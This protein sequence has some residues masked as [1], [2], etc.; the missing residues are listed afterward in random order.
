MKH[1]T[2][3]TQTRAFFW[4]LSSLLVA[5]L[6]MSAALP[7]LANAATI[8]VTNNNDSGAG[9]LRQAITDTVASDTIT[10]DSS[11]AGQTITL[12]SQLTI[13]KNL[14]IDGTGQNITISGNNAVRVFEVTAGTVTFDSLIIANGN[15]S[16]STGS[17]GGGIFNSNG[18]VTVLNSTFD[19]NVANNSGGAIRNEQTLTVKNSTFN[20][21]S[22]SWAGG[23]I[24]NEAILTVKNSTFSGNT[25]GGGNGSAILNG[26]AGTLNLLN[27]ILANS[28]NNSDCYNTGSISTNTNNLIEDNSCNPALSGDSMLNALA[29]NGGDTQTMALQLGSPAIAAGDSAT[30]LTTDQRGESRQTNCDI[31]AY[32]YPSVAPVAAFGTALDFDGTDDYVLANLVTTAIDNISMEAWIN[33]D[34]STSTKQVIFYNG[35]STTNGY[36]LLVDNATNKLQ[37]LVGG[38]IVADSDYVLSIDG[39]HHVALIRRSG[40]WELYVDGNAQTLTSTSTPNLPTGQTG[41]AA[42]FSGIEFFK[43]QLDEVRIWAVARTQ[44]Q[45]QANM[46]QFLQG[47]ESGLVG[48][49]RFDEGTG[50]TAYDSTSNNNHGTLTNMDAANWFDASGDYFQ[51]N[52]DTALS[53]FMIAYDIDGDSL[54]YSIVTNGSKG[55]A[56]FTDPANGD[57]TYTPNADA[58]G[59]D[60]FTY[61]VNDG[62]TDSN[63]VTAAMDITADNDA[64]TFTSTEVTSATAGSVYTYNITTNDVDNLGTELTIT[65]PTQ[66]S[67][68]TT[69]TDNGDGTAFLSG[70]PDGSDAGNHGISLQVSDGTATGTQ[71]FIVNVT[72]VTNPTVANTNDSGAGSLRDAIIAAGVGD[73]ITFDSS[74]AGQTIT[75]SSQLTIGKDLTIDGGNNNITLSGNGAVRIL[76]T[77]AGDITLNNLTITDGSTNTQDG[78]A[79]LVGDSTTSLTINGCTFSNNMAGFNYSGGVIKNEALLLVNNSTFLDN[80]AGYAGAILNSGDALISNST[81]YHNLSIQISGG[82]AA[83]KNQTGRTMTVNNSTLSDNQASNASGGA[84]I[85]NEGT[86]HLT[87]TIIANSLGGGDCVNNGTL[88]TN[89]NN[90]IED[91]SCSATLNGDPNLGSLQDNSGPTHTMSLLP[92]SVALNAG[93]NTAC[94]STDQRG[95]SRPQHNTCDIGA[96]EKRP[97]AFSSTAT[98]SVNEDSAYTYN[99]TLTYAETT[100]GFTPVISATVKPTWLTLTDN[101]DGTGT[102]VGTPTN[103]EVGTHNVTLYLNYGSENVVQSFIITVVNTN[104]APTFTSTALTSVNEDSLYT[105]NITSTDIDVGDTLSLTAPTKP[106]WLTLTDNGNGTGTLTGTPTNAEVGIHNVT[107]RVNDGTVDVD[108]TFT[109]TVNNTNDAPTFTSTAT[110]TINEDS[111][112]SYSITTSDLDVGDSLTFSTPV[113][114]AWLT[115]T[116]N[117][118]GTATLTGT[119]TNS[120]V[121]SHNVTL[122]VNDGTVNLDQSFTVTVNNSNDLPIFTST[123]ITSSDEDSPYSY[124]IAVSE[125]DVTDTLTL[126]ASTK[127]AWLT[128][129]DNG[130]G[131]GTLAGTPTNA[132]VGTHNVTLRVNDGTVNVDQNFTVSVNNINDAPTFTSTEVTAV[133]ED[134]TYTYNIVASDVDVGNSLTLTAP[135]QPAW[136]T[137][138]DNGDGTATLTGTPTNT[139][140]GNNNVTLRVSDG[141]V[142]VDQSFTVTVAK[143]DIYQLTVN[144]EGNGTITTDGINCGDDCQQD[145]FNGTSVTLTATPDS[146]WYFSGLQGDCDSTGTVVINSEKSC[147]VTFVEEQFTLT[148]MILGNGTLTGDN[149]DCDDN[150]TVNYPANTKV[151]LTAQPDQGWQFD[152]FDGDCE[153]DGKIT[154]SSN[155]TCIATFIKGDTDGVSTEIED[156]APNNGD[157]NGDGLKD[158]QQAEV[159]SGPDAV[160][161]AYITLVIHNT[162]CTLQYIN[163]VSLTPEAGYHYPQGQIAFELDNCPQTALTVYYHGDVTGGDGYRQYGPTVPGDSNNTWYDLPNVSLQTATLPNGQTVQTATLTLVD[164]QPGDETAADGSI[165]S[166]GGLRLQV[167]MVGFSAPEYQVAEDSGPATI[168]VSRLEGDTRTLTID[169]ATSDDTAIAGQDYQTSLGTLIWADGQQGDQT[170]TIDIIDNTTHEGDRTLKISLS[171]LTGTGAGMANNTAFLTIHD[172][173]TSPPDGNTDGNTTPPDG[174]TGGSTTS[175][176][177]NTGDSTTSPDG[178]TGDSTTSPDGSTGGSTTPPDGSTGG[179][180]T[181]PDGS[182]DGT[183]TPSDGAVDDTSALPPSFKP[184]V[185]VSGAVTGQTFTGDTLVTKGASV[186]KS[187]FEGN[188]HNQGLVSNSTLKAGALLTGGSL[189]GTTTNN[190]TIT[191]IDFVGTKLSGGTL[192]GTITNSSQIGGTISNV[193][194]AAG[195][196]VK[197][198]ILAGNIDSQGIVSDTTIEPGALL[199]GGRLA[200]TIT[201]RG[202]ITNIEFTG[203]KLSGGT[204]SGTITNSSENGLIEDVQLAAGTTVKGG[205]LAGEIRGDP[206]KPALIMAA[207]IAPGTI[208]SNVHLSST[209]QLPE[210]VVL[211]PGV[212]PATLEDFGLTDEALTTLDAE[213]L[214]EL[215]P[216]VF[217][218]L[219]P[220]QLESIPPEAFSALKPEQL[221]EVQKDTLA[222]LTPEQFEQMPLEALGGLTKDNMGGLPTDVINQITPAHLDA[223]NSDEFKQMPSEDVSKLFTNLDAENVIPQDVEQLIPPGWQVAPDGALT[224]PVGAK[225]TLR[226]LLPPA[227]LPAQVA[228]PSVPDFSA[229][230]G[231]GGRGTPLTT[232]VTLSLA[233]ANLAEFVLSQPKEKGGVLLVKGTG[234]SAGIN[235]SFIPD[236]DNVIQVDTDE[237]PIGLSEDDGG[238][239]TI[240]TPYGQQFKVIPAPQNPVELSKALGDGEVVLGKRGDVMMEDN[241]QTQPGHTAHQVGI[242]DPLIK[243]AP[244]GLSPGLYLPESRTSSEPAKVVYPDGT[245]QT[246]TPTMLSPDTFTEEG[247]EFQGVKDIVFKADGTYSFTYKGQPYLVESHFGLQIGNFAEGEAVEASI[248]PSNGIL[249]Y[250]VVIEEPEEQIRRTHRG[251]GGRRGRSSGNYRRH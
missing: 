93:D 179:T 230:F 63:I 36:G 123:A 142:D 175:P 190:G 129:T 144:K 106:T 95:I 56:N 62:T 3:T 20:S 134:S 7:P 188:I 231:I 216:A 104:D 236:A 73:T 39:W 27:T 251:R 218:V 168:T 72:A 206:N 114:P 31:G 11:I 198:G 68:L 160:T 99:I 159:V 82:G 124:S 139:D 103:N 2:P 4:P 141:T 165:V 228:L 243:P 23:G 167:G 77:T 12:S 238:F 208:L 61:K 54:T 91:G 197:G 211:G 71:N 42:T 119:P 166:T 202:T 146:G 40:T 85:L 193:Q 138:T 5:M 84:G 148:V 105:Y 246:F 207:Q 101:N 172:N 170:F 173:D 45:I 217:G 209:V 64:P 154:L 224:A 6:L 182:T 32:E 57:F 244:E 13:N 186:S 149:I 90:L 108:Q 120:E 83:L 249:T 35:N 70:T 226:T 29:N 117:G 87:N 196:I 245:M 233:E 191:N 240:T 234:N 44:A 136:L 194:L 102:L 92:N 58:T 74:I 125:V 132:E 17:S 158:S 219:E 126:T 205:T 16:N 161:G 156:A 10:F 178:S 153:I 66:P 145:Y 122:R 195:T 21:N 24:S 189:S 76:E 15:T 30:C 135:T 225:V 33:W 22:A 127:P 215:E 94:E 192:S 59:S 181:P 18:N 201:N 96:Y 140:V 250:T 112:Y 52:E 46:H 53:S 204:L 171:N 113:K 25:S 80:L 151:T 65:A 34:G 222:E 111:L 248:A 157:G 184:T 187:V 26:S 9:S 69:L 49:W 86:L 200:G 48:Y 8:T 152:G 137:L 115:L 185:V 177:G 133:S 131:T 147:T 241:G 213:T 14:A 47:N 130:N 37:L 150:C 41:L 164:G 121:G 81:F 50:M 203:A 100:D 97:P 229:G 169:Y 163:T 155:S 55:S 162:D 38:I 180:T 143:T 51:T 212:E 110:T 221:A 214:S 88:S 78:G 239:Y 60:T 235:F 220:E 227:D 98:T 128:L 28:T 19:N 43:G 232:N 67:W 1:T 199:T 176:D 210:D 118:D 174:N 89:S 237:I 109:V 75:L 107:L 223:L 116:D 247:Y 79:I 242:F 183:T